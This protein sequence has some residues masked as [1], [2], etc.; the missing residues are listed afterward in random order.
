MRR[1]LTAEDCDVVVGI[2]GGQGSLKVCLQTLCKESNNNLN[3]KRSIYSEGVA[4]K[5]SL[6]SSVN[7]LVL[8]GLIPN[9]PENH[10]NINLIMK[11]M[12]MEGLEFLK[13]IDIKLVMILVG[14]SGGKPKF[15]CPFCSSA[16]PFKEQ[17]ILYTVARLVEL[18]E[19]FLAAGSPNDDQMKFEN[20]INPPIITCRDMEKTVLDMVVP[21]ELHLLIGSVDKLM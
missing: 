1:G 4:A 14:K 5:E 16:Q 18:H 11:E 12:G 9:C 17:G 19:S 3:K 15:G 21:P 20:M 7:R 8:L 2:D 6:L 13:S 10:Y